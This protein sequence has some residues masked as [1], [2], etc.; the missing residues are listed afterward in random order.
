MFPRYITLLTLPSLS[1]ATH[2]PGALA[3][4]RRDD[5]CRR[6]LGLVVSA[7]DGG[8]GGAPGGESSSAGDPPPSPWDAAL[9]EDACVIEQ[10]LTPELCTPMVSPLGWNAP[11]GWSP[12]HKRKMG[13][14]EG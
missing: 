10:D 7:A 11:Q 13:R 14:K 6:R 2:A 4:R 3:S 5:R 8:A 12:P 9:D 1:Q